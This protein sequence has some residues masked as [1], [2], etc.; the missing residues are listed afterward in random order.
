M[1]RWK[2]DLKDWHGSASLPWQTMRPRVMS[3]FGKK[4]SW[5]FST[6]STQTSP[7]GVTITPCSRPSLPPKLM[8]SGGVSGLPFLSNTAIALLP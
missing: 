7:L 6:P 4:T 2:G 1:A 5:L 8:P 3:P